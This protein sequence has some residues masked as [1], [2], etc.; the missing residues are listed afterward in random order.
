MAEVVAVDDPA[1]ARLRD[2]VDLRDVQ[3]RKLLE[4]ERGVFIAEGEKV[5]R[6]AVESGHQARSFL[7]APRWLETLSDVLDTTDAPVF[8]MPEAEIERVTGFHVHRGALASLDR[9]PVPPVEEVLANARRVVVAED[10]MDHTNVGAVFRSVAALG[11]DAVILSPRCAD[12]LYRR[13]VKV[14]MGSVFWL[15]Y[16]RVDDWYGFPELLRSLGWTSLAMTLAED[17]RDLRDVAPADPGEK[18]ALLVGAEGDGLSPHWS[19]SADVRVTIPMAADIDS[20]N[21]AAATA[22]A[23]WALAG[24][25]VG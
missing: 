7:M 11:F 4:S 10:L 1:D 20:L 6:R 8:V 2:Y 15:P 3:L 5:V 16:A 17:A 18:I 25:A 24:P 19:R 14:S 13:A 9:K 12:P 23:C 22:V 21:V